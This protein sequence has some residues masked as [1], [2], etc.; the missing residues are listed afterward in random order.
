[1][2]IT[3]LIGRSYELEIDGVYYVIGRVGGADSLLMFNLHLKGCKIEDYFVTVHFC[4]NIWIYRYFEGDIIDN[5]LF[6]KVC[7]LIDE[8]VASKLIPYRNDSF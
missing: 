4:D 5:D 2:K 8:G 7:Y 6:Y 1:M 3:Y